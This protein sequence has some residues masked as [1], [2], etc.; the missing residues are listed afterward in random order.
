MVTTL[1]NTEQQAVSIPGANP[2]IHPSSNPYLPRHIHRSEV[3]RRHTPMESLPRA[4]TVW[5]DLA[6]TRAGSITPV[7]FIREVHRTI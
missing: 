7:W 4:R 3:R 5:A 1:G 6:T 2:A